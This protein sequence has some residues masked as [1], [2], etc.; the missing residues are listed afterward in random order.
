MQQ[1]ADSSQAYSYKNPAIQ[2]LKGWV[3]LD[4]GEGLLADDH[5]DEAVKLH[6]QAIAEGGEYWTAYRY[7]GDA[8]YAMGDWDSAVRDLT[9]AN[10]LFPGNSRVVMFLAFATARQKNPEASI[11]WTS[12]Y[13]MLENPDEEFFRLNEANRRELK[14]QGKENW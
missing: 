11:I 1:L 14:A 7:R 2:F 4:Q 10:R 6:T 13:L 12:Q 9:H 3:S 5:D 8:Y